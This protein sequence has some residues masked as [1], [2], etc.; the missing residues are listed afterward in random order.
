MIKFRG[1]KPTPEALAQL[2]QEQQEQ[3]PGQQ[4]QQQQQQQSQLQ[5]SQPP[6]PPPQQQ[7][8]QQQQ[9]SDKCEDESEGMGETTGTSEAVGSYA[10]AMHATPVNYKHVWKLLAARCVGLAREPGMAGM[11]GGEWKDGQGY[12]LQRLSP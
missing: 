6:P 11:G 5:Q 8:Q 10:Q 4:Q 12:L 2:Q 7:Q 3:E 1:L 9:T